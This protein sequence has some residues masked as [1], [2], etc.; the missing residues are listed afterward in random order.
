MRGGIRDAVVPAETHG[1]DGRGRGHV[2]HGGGLLHDNQGWHAYDEKGGRWGEG[3][4]RVGLN[5]GVCKRGERG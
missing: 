3:Q 1:F 5:R 2:Q 4:T